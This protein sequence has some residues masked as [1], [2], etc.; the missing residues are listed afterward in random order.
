MQTRAAIHT[1]SVF[2]KYA[3]L[4]LATNNAI[5]PLDLMQDAR[6]LPTQTVAN[7]RRLLV[8][9]EQAWVSPNTTVG[10]CRDDT[11]TS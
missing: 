8:A 5:S 7:R 2:E 1:I 6:G 11:A 10:Y 4:E 3:L 9:A